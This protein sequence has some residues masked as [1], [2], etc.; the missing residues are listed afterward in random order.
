MTE[1]N[2]TRKLTKAQITGKVQFENEDKAAAGLKVVA[3]VAGTKKQLGSAV[4]DAAGKYKIEFNRS[5]VEDVD[6]AVSP[7]VDSIRLKVMPKATRFVSKKEWEK[8]KTNILE[9]NAVVVYALAKLWETI[10]KPYTVYGFVQ[11]AVPDLQHP[12]NYLNP[13]PIPGVTVHVYDVSTP[14]LMP[15]GFKTKYSVKELATAVTDADGLFFINFDWCYVL[16]NYSYPPYLTPI[17]MLPDVEPDLLFRVTQKV[18][19]A[20]ALLYDEDPSKARHNVPQNPPLGVTLTVEGEVVL[21]DDPF[22]DIVGD[23]EFHGIGSVLISEMNQTA[24]DIEMKGYATN[25]WAKDSPFGSAVDVKGQF[26]Q[27]LNG[28]Y[29]QVLYAKWPD[30]TTPPA[31]ADFTPILDETW[32]VAKKIAGEWTTVSIAPETLLSVG[33]GFYKIPDYTDI[34]TTSKD[35]LINWNTNRMDL[36]V[37]RYPDGRYSL[38][39]KAFNSNGTPINP[40]I[41]SNLKLVVVVDNSWPTALLEKIGDLD[42]LRTDDNTPYVPVCPVFE[43]PKTNVVRNLT[44]RFDATDLKHF[45]YY[46]LSFIT[47]HNTYMDQ[48]KKVYEGKDPDGKERFGV[49]KYHKGAD[50]LQPDDHKPIGGFPDETYDWNI[51]NADVVKCAYQVRLG[52][53]DRVINGYDHIHYAED[54]MHIV[55]DIEP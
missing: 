47:G 50:T 7:N 14:L 17:F 11:K 36:G 46:T 18:N 23:F 29:Y 21:A 20:D 5:S 39:V 43:R 16:R 26:K 30:E 2:F 49:T 8:A 31:E 12:G 38:K 4:T 42:V 40:Q 55:I 48:I 54:T 22:E 53:W 28:K 10:C 19:N 45:W 15:I 27:A 35:I 13:V 41:N 52:V 1:R 6:I 33:G 44:V 32:N 51:G 24:A 9:V 3:Y 25:S 34:Y 37:R